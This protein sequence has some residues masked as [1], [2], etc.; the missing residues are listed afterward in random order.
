MCDVSRR[1]LHVMVREG[2]C[3]VMCGEER[4]SV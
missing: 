2:V 1:G 3:N 4:S